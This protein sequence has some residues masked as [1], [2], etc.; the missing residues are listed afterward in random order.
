MD[1]LMD[2]LRGES[3]HKLVLFLLTEDLLSTAPVPRPTPLRATATATDGL[4]E[5]P[6]AL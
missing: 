1:E 6:V 3:G 4:A 5:I 2:G